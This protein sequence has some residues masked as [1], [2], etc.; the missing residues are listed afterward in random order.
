M[1]NAIMILLSWKFYRI[2]DLQEVLNVPLKVHIQSELQH[3]LA[4]PGENRNKQI[5]H[6]VPSTF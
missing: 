2:I 1:T 5:S 6:T 3:F 4:T